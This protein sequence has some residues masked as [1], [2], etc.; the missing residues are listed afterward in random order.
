MPKWVNN[1]NK[2][3]DKMIRQKQELEVSLAWELLE[4]FNTKP[5]L[6]GFY[7]H[8]VERALA[9]MV[10]AS[11]FSTEAKAA[12]QKAID[13]NKKIDMK[14]LTRCLP[15]EVPPTR[16]GD[17]TFAT[18]PRAR[19]SVDE[20]SPADLKAF[21][22]PKE[23][24]TFDAQDCSDVVRLYGEFV[25]NAGPKG[26]KLIIDK[27]EQDY[28]KL[29][30]DRKSGQKGATTSY[31]DVWNKGEDPK[32]K[33]GRHRK[34]VSTQY[35]DVMKK[36][37]SQLLSV[38]EF[39]IS[40]KG[41]QSLFQLKDT[42]TINKIDSWF[43]LVPAADISGTTTD[44]IFFIQRFF[45]QMFLG[46][47]DKMFFM[48]PLATIVAGAHHSTLEVATPLSQNGLIDYAV[49]QYTSLFIPSTASNPAAGGLKSALEA[50]EKHKQNHLMCVGY[51]GDFK[52]KKDIEVAGAY[53]FDPKEAGEFFKMANAKKLLGAFQKENAFPTQA[54][55][56]AYL[57]K[58]G[59]PKTT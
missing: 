44:T 26:V 9:E 46:A 36:K 37:G 30:K 57:Q 56:R 22:D 1:V 15:G 33:W 12:C 49:G 5:T 42:S 29:E 58:N 3:V 2:E 25:E 35:D 17:G 34:F 31:I 6:I 7:R 28:E 11:E 51:T 20:K 27:V 45:G 47:F 52:N 43:G 18:N 24:D 16:K 8:A 39:L 32:M 21:L 55:V 14:I 38:Q 59:F 13:S 23:L 10:T 54:D 19:K 41:G 4:E 48:L 40:F 50:A 53:V